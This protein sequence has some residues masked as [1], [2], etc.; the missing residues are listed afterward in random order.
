VNNVGKNRK[1]K[2]YDQFKGKT[3]ELEDKKR[4]PKGFYRDNPTKSK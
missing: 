1:K 4:M 2:T 3:Q